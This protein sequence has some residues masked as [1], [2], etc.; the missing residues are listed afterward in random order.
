[1]YPSIKQYPIIV[2]FHYQPFSLQ[3]LDLDRDYPDVVV[4]RTEVNHH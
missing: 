2:A 3:K 4:L 1:M